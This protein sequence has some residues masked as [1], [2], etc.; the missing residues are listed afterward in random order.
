MSSEQEINLYKNLYLSIYDIFERKGKKEKLKPLNLEHDKL[1]INVIFREVVKPKE[2]FTSWDDEKWVES[3]KIP[4]ICL[5]SFLYKKN[6]NLHY[7]YNLTSNEELKQNMLSSYKNLVRVVK[8]LESME[9]A[10]NLFV[11][12]S[13]DLEKI[14]N[15]KLELVLN[16]KN[17]KEPKNL[18]NFIDLLYHKQFRESIVNGI[19]SGI[20]SIDIDSLKEFKETP[21]A[22]L[23]SIEELCTMDNISTCLIFLMSLDL[24]GDVFANES[25]YN[26]VKNYIHEINKNSE[27]IQRLFKNID[28]KVKNCSVVYKNKINLIILDNKKDFILELKNSKNKASLTTDLLTN[29][30]T[31]NDGQ[32][33]K[34][35]TVDLIKRIREIIF[36][37]IQT[38]M[39]LSS[40]PNEEKVNKLNDFIK[41][42]IISNIEDNEE[43]GSINI[44]KENE[45][46]FLDKNTDSDFS[47]IKKDISNKIKETVKELF[48]S[49]NNVED[50]KELIRIKNEF[51]ENMKCLP[52]LDFSK[53]SKDEFNIFYNLTVKIFK[54]PEQV[55]FLLIKF[56]NADI[57]KKNIYNFEN[58]SGIHI[59]PEIKEKI[60]NKSLQ[61]LQEIIDSL[62]G[63]KDLTN[64]EKFATVLAKM[65]DY[66]LYYVL[67]LKS[68]N[69][70]TNIVKQKKT[71]V[72]RR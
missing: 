11:D 35:T 34:F 7:I 69:I 38:V 43:V 27:Q 29:F 23:D 61:A 1:F 71:V 12:T 5:L 10:T 72:Q 36:L 51:V 20:N 48:E 13:V 3:M 31:F 45:F 17:Y 44:D 30:N 8:L 18:A 65:V 58:D 40:L 9:E 39:E 25:L 70:K 49:L 6:I 46:I 28:E 47:S 57:I 19:L 24:K 37:V 41:T 53:I 66:G 21:I 14:K 59:N 60:G 54:K 4:E 63:L 55:K 56:L 32:Y 68:S 50:I 42:Y 15:K 26:M 16:I 62:L 67:K 64:I 22:Y 52:Q 33:I 2:D